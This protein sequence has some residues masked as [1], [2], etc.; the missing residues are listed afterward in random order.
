ML[1]SVNRLAEIVPRIS[2]RRLWYLFLFALACTNTTSDSNGYCKVDKDRTLH[3]GSASE[4]AATD[5]SDFVSYSCTGGA[6]PDLEQASYNQGV[7][8]GL[9]CAK[10][11]ES[12]GKKQGYCCTAEVTECAYDPAA[13]CDEP[14]YG[15]QCRGANRPEMLNPALTCSNGVKQDELINYCCTDTPQTPGCQQSDAVQCS[16]RLM[17]W[18]CRGDSLPKGEELGANKSRADFYYLLCPTPTPAENPEYNNYCCYMPAL[19]PPGGSCVQNTEVPGC[20]P[21]RFGFSCYGPETPEKDY[22]P[23]RCPEPGF[24]GRSAEGYPATLYC[25]DFQ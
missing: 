17:G 23:M 7:P 3:C 2:R 24:A 9:I 15:F 19:L 25:C 1:R 20:A 10:R 11:G 14:R 4:E 5:T 18:T 16:P 12:D 21:G 13:S 22:L 6:R 8:Q